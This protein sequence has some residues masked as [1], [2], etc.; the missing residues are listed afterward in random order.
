MD[1]GGEDGQNKGS[2]DLGS[3]F[4]SDHSYRPLKRTR[5]AT[6]LR[7]DRALGGLP[8]RFTAKTRNNTALQ[9]AKLIHPPLKRHHQLAALV[10]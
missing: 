4:L 2:K 3:G 7:K 6:E 8:P 1:R 10:T 5:W 9:P